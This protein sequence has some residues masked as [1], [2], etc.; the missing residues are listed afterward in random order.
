MRTFIVWTGL[1]VLT[2]FY[3]TVTWVAALLG[4][5]DREGS[6]YRRAPKAWARALCRLAGVRVVVHGMERLHDGTP[7]ILMANHISLFDVFALAA[8]LPRMV[9]VAKAE[10]GRIPIFGRGARAA[11]QLFIERGNRKAAF[12]AYEVAAA[13]IRDG[14]TVIVFPEGTRGASRE[15]R[16]FKKGPFV[17]AIS[18]GVPIVPVLIHGAFEVQR[19]GS[20]RVEP[21]EIHLHFL[22]DIA[23]GG[24][25][26]E[27][28]DQLAQKVHAVMRREQHTRY[29]VESP[30]WTTT[31]PLTPAS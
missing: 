11:G 31:T 30:P 16:P 22:D 18:A 27:H 26:Y 15:L 3:A 25:T 2:P 1:L 14:A 28:R 8:V 19:K 21:G 9:F 29:G 24:L 12:A 6:I 17:L 20:L 13:R 23:T 5:K 7:R 4:V 10:L